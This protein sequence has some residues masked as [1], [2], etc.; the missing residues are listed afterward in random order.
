MLLKNCSSWKNAQ[1][2]DVN[3]IYK[4]CGKFIAVKVTATIRGF[5]TAETFAET[6]WHYASLRTR[7]RKSQEIILGNF[8][9]DSKIWAS[10]NKYSTLESLTEHCFVEQ[11]TG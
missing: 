11:E 10:S 4:I 2:F 8:A 3:V 9:S 1:L 6:K 5:S 7:I